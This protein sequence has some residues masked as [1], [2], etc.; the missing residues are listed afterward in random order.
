MLCLDDCFTTIMLTQPAEITQFIFGQPLSGLW[1][2]IDV[3]ARFV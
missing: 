1:Q 3:A 2:G